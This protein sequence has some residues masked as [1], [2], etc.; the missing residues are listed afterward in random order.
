VGAEGAAVSD[1]FDYA[2]SG[3]VGTAFGFWLAA[4]LSSENDWLNDGPRKCIY[5][6]AQHQMAVVECEDTFAVCGVDGR[7]ELVQWRLE[8]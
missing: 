3:V 6:C 8:R 4:T 2:I 7:R 1:S 5:E